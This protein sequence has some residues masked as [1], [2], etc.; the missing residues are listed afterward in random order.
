MFELILFYSKNTQ[1]EVLRWVDERCVSLPKSWLQLFCLFCSTW[2]GNSNIIILRW[3]YNSNWM[4]NR[5]LKTSKCCEL[6]WEDSSNWMLSRMMR[7]FQCR[8][9]QYIIKKK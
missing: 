9:R 3:E 8:K 6:W 1:Q 4:S 7:T 5:E 2:D